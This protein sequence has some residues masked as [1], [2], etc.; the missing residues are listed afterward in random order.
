YPRSSLLALTL[1]LSLYFIAG[2]FSRAA[3]AL[4]A[5]Y[6]SWDWAVASGAV[7]VAVG[8]ML[9]VRGPTDALWVLGAA[10]GVDLIFSGWALL[11][12][13]AAVKQRFPSDRI[14]T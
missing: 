11:M 6:P 3:V 14:S 4:S 7:S 2:G 13:A 1:V 9:A 5:R 10:I 12:L 8:V